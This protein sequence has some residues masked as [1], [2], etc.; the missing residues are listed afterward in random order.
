MNSFCVFDIQLRKISCFDL[1]R[2]ISDGNIKPDFTVNLGSQ[3]GIPL[4]LNGLPDANGFIITGIFPEPYR[5]LIADRTGSI[6]KKSGLIPHQKGS[7]PINVF[8]HAYTVYPL[9]NL[10]GDK[11]A[12]GYKYTNIF[13]IYSLSGELL[14]RTHVGDEALEP[15]FKTR[16]TSQGPTMALGPDTLNGFT[17]ITA[18]RSN[19]FALYS[20]HNFYTPRSGQANT[21]LI[22]NW[23]GQ[24]KATLK[25]GKFVR[26]CAVTLNE[27]KLYCVDQTSLEPSIIEYKIPSID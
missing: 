25:L 9:S 18:G 17:H 7:E 14:M 13:E 23:N 21:I 5:F 26:Q 19:I 22:Y 8:Q 11:I 3:S 20:G 2:V 24:H 15:F 6:V 12:F 10:G 4:R 16:Q 1:N 27:E